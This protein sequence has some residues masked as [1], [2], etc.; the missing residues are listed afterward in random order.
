MCQ[1]LSHSGEVTLNDPRVGKREGV[2]VR[3]VLVRESKPTGSDEPIEWLLLTSLP[4]KTRDD[5]E[6]VIHYYL[7][8]WMIELFFKVLKSGCKI[9]SRRFE[10]MDRF[11]PALALYLII[12]WRSLYVCRLS[13]TLATKP[14]THLYTDD[15]WK[16]VW[17]VVKRAPL[18]KSPPTAMENDS[19]NC[20]AWRLHKSQERRSTRPSIPLAGDFNQ[21][22]SSPTVGL[23]SAQERNRLVC[24]N[25]GT[26][27]WTLHSETPGSRARVHHLVRRRS[28]CPRRIANR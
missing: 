21:C 1:S 25:E 19:I 27:G 9:E 11:L 2:T 18:P 20:A 4:V 14:C 26:R 3:A 8:R 13:R 12:A 28:S 10:H 15:E 16:S 5:V 23:P 6:T 17:Q 22:T 24:N 7:M